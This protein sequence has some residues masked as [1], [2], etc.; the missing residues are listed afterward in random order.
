MTAGIGGDDWNQ[1]FLEDTLGI[2]KIQLLV[3]K[4]LVFF[5]LIYDTVYI[6]MIYDTVYI[7]VVYVENT[8]EMTIQREFYFFYIFKYYYFEVI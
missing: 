4:D 1:G 6:C 7:Y 8:K 3:S 5:C 2:S